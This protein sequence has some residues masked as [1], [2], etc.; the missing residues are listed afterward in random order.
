MKAVPS[1]D[2]PLRVLY[3]LRFQLTAAVGLLLTKDL[4][5]HLRPATPRDVIIAS[6]VP[7]RKFVSHDLY[8]TTESIA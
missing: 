2:D 1:S 7:Y 5:A 8:V 3:S 6:R 4:D